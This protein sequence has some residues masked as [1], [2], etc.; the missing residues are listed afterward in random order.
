MRSPNSSK[1]HDDIS[2]SASEQP[3]AAKANMNIGNVRDV[4]VRK[5]KRSLE[6]PGGALKGMPAVYGP[7]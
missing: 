3:H 7:E 5:R 1:K 6:Q 4:P 2:L